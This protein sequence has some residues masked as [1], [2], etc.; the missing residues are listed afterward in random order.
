MEAIDILTGQHVTIQYEPAGILRRGCALVIDWVILFLYFY[1]LF[2]SLLQWGDAIPPYMRNITVF[3]VLFPCICYHFLFEILMGGKT[4]G[5]L[6][7]G[8]R[9]TNLDGSTPGLSSYFLRWILLPVDLFPAGMGIGGLFIA[10]SKNRQRIGDL[11]AGTIVVRN[12]KPPRFDLDKDFQ[13]FSDDYQPTF[14]QVELLS[15]GQIRFISYL[16]YD[17]RNKKAISSSIQS[18]SQK[19]KTMLNVESHLDD[20]R[21]LETL[22][23]DY[24]YYA[25]HSF[26]YFSGNSI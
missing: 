4:P 12:A 17:P 9:V 8:T 5:K 7:A 21:F 20:R 14:S 1:I 18:L 15:D 2:V 25:W 26:S 24:N 10:F 13:E 16:L 22:V 23:K 3:I 6:I 19:V 11:A